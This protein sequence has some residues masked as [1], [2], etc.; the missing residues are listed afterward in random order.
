VVAP[1]LV[2][3]VGPGPARRILLQGGTVSGQRAMEL[4]MVERA[5]P[6]AELDA[7]VEDTVGR[8][9]AA[10]PGAVRATKKLLNEIEGE[11]LATQVRRGAELS[12]QVLAGE[13]AQRMLRKVLGA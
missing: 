5:V 1:W 8:L 3:A 11:A 12:A 6:A 13:E 7:L 4:G 2:R 10:G 9:A